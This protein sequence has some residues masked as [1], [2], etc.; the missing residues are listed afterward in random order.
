MACRS[1]APVKSETERKSPLAST[2]REGCRARR[3]QVIETHIS[4]VLSR[5]ERL[6]QR[7]R[8]GTRTM[9]KE[10]VSVTDDRNGIGG[11]HGT[12]FPIRGH[13]EMGLSDVVR[14]TFRSKAPNDS[15]PVK[16]CAYLVRIREVGVVAPSRNLRRPALRC[17]RRSALRPCSYRRYTLTTVP[18]CAERVAARAIRC[19][20]IPSSHVIGG[21][22]WSRRFCTKSWSWTM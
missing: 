5:A 9:N 19:A 17:K 20:A 16:H 8:R 1:G 10:T 14:C 2:R 15:A 11:G 13:N 18:S 4:Q 6:E 22:R 21:G 12:G 7:S 3:V